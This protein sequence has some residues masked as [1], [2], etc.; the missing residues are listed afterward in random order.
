M[1]CPLL[2][3]RTVFALPSPLQL[4]K[5]LASVRRGDGM[6]VKTPEV[7][8]AYW[9][10]KS[11]M[12]YLEGERTLKWIMGVIAK[13]PARAREVLTSLADYGDPQRH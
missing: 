8:Y 1:D 12:A 3:Y 6:R 5:I 9:L 4:D 11:M 10:R 2:Y 7:S 13:D